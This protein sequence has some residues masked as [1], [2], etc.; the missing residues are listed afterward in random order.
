M[1]R[2]LHEKATRFSWPHP[3]RTQPQ[4][5]VGKDSAFEKRVELVFD[6]L[7]QA[8]RTPGFD[9]GEERFEMFLRH[10]IQR[11]FLW[12]P[13]RIVDRVCSRCAQRRFALQAHPG[14]NARTTG[15]RH[16]NPAG[17]SAG[18]LGCMFIV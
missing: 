4:K 6:K 18:R 16:R 7:R 17:E 9:F 15:P 8:P 14:G 10:A 11:R 3:A 2:R 1:P 5:P 12:L 13:P